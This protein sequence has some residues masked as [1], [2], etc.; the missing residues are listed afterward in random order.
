ML[1]GVFV[2]FSLQIEE[3]FPNIIGGG[4]KLFRFFMTLFLCAGVLLLT[5][6]SYIV[7]NYLRKVY[8]LDMT[9][10]LLGTLML[11]L[12]VISVVLGTSRIAKTMYFAKDNK[13]FA[14]F[15]VTAQQI[16]L[17]KLLVICVSELIGSLFYYF[18]LLLAFGIMG[19]FGIAYYLLL[20]PVI[21]IEVILCIGV[22][23]IITVPFM[24]VVRIL[25][26][27]NVALI[28][29]ALLLLA[30]VFML[31]MQLLN[32]L[33]EFAFVTN[34]VETLE[35][36]NALLAALSQGTYIFGLFSEIL[37][38]ENIMGSLGILCLISFVLLIFA[39]MLNIL[40]FK[41]Y[42]SDVEKKEQVVK[43]R[44]FC[45]ENNKFVSIFK[46]DIKSLFRSLSQLVQYFL[47]ALMMPV[48]ILCC[49]QLL[50]VVEVSELGKA[51]LTGTNILLFAL[52]IFM[53]TTYCSTAVSSEGGNY[54]LL[55][56]FP[57][58]FEKLALSKILLNVVVVSAL[59]VVSLA[60]TVVFGYLDIL[61]ALL[62]FVSGLAWVI[63]GCFSS[64]ECDLKKPSLD[65]YSETDLLSNS[66]AYTI[67]TLSGLLS[68]AV[69]GIMAI[70]LAQH[71]NVVV[72]W[73]A[74]ISVSIVYAVIRAHTF[75]SRLKYYFYNLE[76]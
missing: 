69:V 3:N 26:K 12:A 52:L 29:A 58:E 33:F 53:S 6:V 39:W 36:I 22:A 70:V 71:T 18:P 72:M 54:Y 74:V 15:P 34:P 21:F 20:L 75:K 30:G 48:F 42:S 11:L 9:K 38:L 40:L 50:L 61:T 23:A 19:Q 17:S 59:L 37:F 51:I 46:K 56:I 13:L 76:V 14:T 10:D 43:S 44:D 60:L 32:G 28:C 65:W 47:Y 27:S 7:L 66:N 25:Q 31:Y 41:S 49:N 4:K 8:L 16:Y 2:L 63:A 67:S 24:A 55:K 64:Y 5:G 62:I 73:I 68:G 45:V 35:K 1:K 57:I